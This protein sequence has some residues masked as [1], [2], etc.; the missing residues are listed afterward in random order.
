MRKLSEMMQPLIKLK[1]K[2]D[3]EEEKKILNDTLEDIK[4]LSST[5]NNQAKRITK[6]EQIEWERN[7]AKEQL[8]E[9]GY[10]IGEQISYPVAIKPKQTGRYIGKLCINDRTYYDIAYFDGMNWTTYVDG[11]QTPLITGV[12]ILEYRK[13]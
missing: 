10:E 8:K 2:T 13:L 4:W 5:V 12:S 7:T 1:D 6:F 3:N 9:L 11:R